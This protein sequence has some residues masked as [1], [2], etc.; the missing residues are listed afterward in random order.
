M[1]ELEHAKKSCENGKKWDEP[2]P[3]SCENSQLFFSNENENEK[4]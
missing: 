4:V 3:H 2:P 1:D